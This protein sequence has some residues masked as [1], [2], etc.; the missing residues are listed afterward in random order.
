MRM[1]LASSVV[2]AATAA[3]AAPETLTVSSDAFDANTAI[4]TQYTCDGAGKAPLLTWSE[5]P[6]GT[7]SIAVLV[8]DP[9]A[10]RGPFTH[11]LVTNLPADKR[12]VDLGSALP[13][14]ATLQ[15]NDSGASGYL[16]PCPEDGRHHYHFR[17]FALDARI[18]PAPITRAVSRDS[19]LRGIRDH[20]LAQ[21]ELVGTY[22]PR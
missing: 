12:S 18:R 7:K 8:D 5:V 3:S 4:P 15:R 14:G 22:A 2:L 6:A 13:A 9:D 10:A 16:A 17:V 19:F 20:V 1:L 11:V 21:G